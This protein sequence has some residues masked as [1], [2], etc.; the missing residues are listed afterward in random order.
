MCSFNL[1]VNFGPLVTSE[2][3]SVQNISAIANALKEF[4]T[5]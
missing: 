2:A 4:E 1:Y 3:Q 5:I